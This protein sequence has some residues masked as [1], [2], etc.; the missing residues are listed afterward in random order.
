M[1]FGNH[2]F[3]SLLILIYLVTLLF[4]PKLKPVFANTIVVSGKGHISQDDN[5]FELDE[6]LNESIKMINK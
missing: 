1:P 2:N 5:V 3:I 4:E 6:I